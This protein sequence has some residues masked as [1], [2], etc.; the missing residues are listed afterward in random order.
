MPAVMIYG[1]RC[2]IYQR[3]FPAEE[4]F[5]EVEMV[6]VSGKEV[7]AFWIG[8]YEVTQKLYESVMGDNP[9]YFKGARLP[10]EQVSWFNAVEFC[11]RL[12]V[13]TGLKQY[14]NIDKNR[15]DPENRNSGTRWTVTVNG[16]ADG[17]R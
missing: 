4:K 13:M 17:F 5:G 10:V 15:D 7:K 14:Y 8:K 12:S 2:S 1:D 9:S 3:S 6:L 16:D 11:N